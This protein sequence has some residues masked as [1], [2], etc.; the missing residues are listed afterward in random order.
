MTARR[1]EAEAR[2]SLDDRRRVSADGV[3][4]SRYAGVKDVMPGLASLGDD[5]DGPAS[6]VQV[7]KV[8]YDADRISHEVLMRTYW[9]HADPVKADGQFKELGPQYRGAVW[10]SGAVERT[11]VSAG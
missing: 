7:V 8:T 10:V 3:P 2:E 1:S 11:E 4:Y 9:K 6:P 5:D